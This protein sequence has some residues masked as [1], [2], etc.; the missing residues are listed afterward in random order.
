MGSTFGTPVFSADGVVATPHYLASLAG[1]EVL[2]DG[3]SA[4]DAANAANLVRGVVWPHMCGLGGDLFAQVFHGDL[5]GLNASGRAGA[6]M[7]G[8]AYR[9]RGVDQMPVRGPLS[10]TVP[11]AVGGWFALHERWGRLG[12]DRLARDAIRHARDGFRVTAFLSQA[13]AANRVLLGPDQPVP[14]AGDLLAQ[15][16]LARSMELVVAEGPSI[17]YGGR[18]GERIAEYLGEQGSLLTGDDFAAHRV[19]WVEPIGVEYRDVRVTQLPPNSQGIALLQIL[20]MLDGAD[21]AGWNTAERLHHL[22]ERK[23]LAF[24][25]RDAYVAD[26]AC[27]EVPVEKLLE[28]AYAARR[29]ALVGPA[30][31][32]YAA[33]PG[34]P[35]G[36]TIYLC[37][38]DRD[39]NVVSLI[40]SL[41][42]QWGS[43]VHVPGTGI[44]LQ[45]RGAGFVLRDGHPNV[46]APG[47]RPLHTLMPGFALRDG[48]PW[49]AF[50]TRGADAQPQTGLQVLTALLDLGLDLQ[51]AMEAPRWVHAAPGDRFPRDAVVLEERFGQQVADDLITRGHRVIL[52]DP[53]DMVMGTAQMIQVDQTRGCYVA[54]SDPRGDGVAL[55]I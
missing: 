2:R 8:D 33:G 6:G 42:A 51:A 34:A 9:A 17:M 21:V 32:S 15:P 25:D 29:A 18:L 24:A 3:G 5:A 52:T 44:T 54:A 26:P 12:M 28:P 22:V 46:L 37:A 49:L 7:T 50:G 48:R 30:A 10:V 16:D 45:N 27:V 14:R 55:A 23:K 40:Q 39:G 4:V 20:G 36:D 53:V 47:K 43:G 1:A 11:G 13:I 35:S 38:A 31:G 41:F 19:E